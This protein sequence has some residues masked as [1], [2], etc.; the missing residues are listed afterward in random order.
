MLDY[1]TKSSQW[2]I[3]KEIVVVYEAFIGE[4]PSSSKAAHSKC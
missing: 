3:F 1:I 4:L 2:L